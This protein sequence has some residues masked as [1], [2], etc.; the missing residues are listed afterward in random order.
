M[1]CL[2]VNGDE[3]DQINEQVKKTGMTF[4]SYARD[5][6]LDKDIIVVPEI[7]GFSSQ[8]NQIGN[9]LNQLT[10]LAHK[11]IIQTVYVQEAVDALRQIYKELIRIRR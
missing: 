9:N 2:R 11:G 3:L 6:L 7:K 4:S 1:L 5:A 10:V 8:L